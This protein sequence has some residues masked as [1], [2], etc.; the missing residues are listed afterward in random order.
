MAQV[1]TER[2]EDTDEQFKVR[3]T[4]N[5]VVKPLR[6][7]EDE[8]L[9]AVLTAAIAEFKVQS[10]PHTMGL[11]TEANVQIAG[12]RP[13]GTDIPSQTVEQAGIERDQI[14]VL[15]QTIVQGG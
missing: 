13:D 3:V 10:Q 12:R 2:T 11:F 6:V 14:L 7:G 1:D 8:A 5:G 15:R 9:P 4:F